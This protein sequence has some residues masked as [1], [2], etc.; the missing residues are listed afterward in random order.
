MK[1]CIFT[2]EFPPHCGGAGYYIYE[3]A[4]AL[5]ENDVDVVIYS[6]GNITNNIHEKIKMFTVPSFRPHVITYNFFL[7]KFANDIKKERFDLFIHNEC[8]GFFLPKDNYK[9]NNHIMIIHHLSNEEPYNSINKYIRLQFWQKLQDVM[10]SKVDRLIFVNDDIAN[11]GSKRYSKKYLIVPN[12]I[13]VNKFKQIPKKN[14]DNLRKKFGNRIVMFYPGGATND[15]KGL[16]QFLSVVVDLL[17]HHNNFVLLVTGSNTKVINRVRRAIHEKKLED[18]VLLLRTLSSS[19]ILLYYHISD[20]IIF[21]SLY[22]GFGRPILEAMASRKVV[23]T[24]PVGIAAKVIQTGINGF[25]SRNTQDFL[26]TLVCLFDDADLR[27]AIGK[28]AQQDIALDE[29]YNWDFIVKNLMK[30]INWSV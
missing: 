25:I 23:V 27:K 20:I 7:R 9:K 19:D 24:Y 13:S 16:L 3:L 5:A 15:R 6:R 12:G 4:Q 1:V 8:S 28:K 21:P 26:T 2:Y 30:N 10:V 17:Q 29:T 14:I 18:Y 11:N 22:E